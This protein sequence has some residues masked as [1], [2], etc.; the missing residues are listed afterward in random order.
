LTDASVEPTAHHH[1]RSSSTRSIH[2][3]FLV[4]GLI[5]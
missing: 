3:W 5:R 1:C 4:T 2:D